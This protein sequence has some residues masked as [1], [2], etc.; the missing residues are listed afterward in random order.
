MVVNKD[1]KSAGARKKLSLIGHGG[2]WCKS[3]RA[4]YKVEKSFKSELNK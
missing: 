2:Y 3:F 4:F 1:I